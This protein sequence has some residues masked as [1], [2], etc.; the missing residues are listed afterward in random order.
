[1]H[2]TVDAGCDTNGTAMPIQSRYDPRVRKKNAQGRKDKYSAE[3]P[4]RKFA[5]LVQ[6]FL[7]RVR[8]ESAGKGGKH[9]KPNANANEQGQRE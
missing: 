4:D 1:M 3:Y 2:K 7:Q 9:E 5:A 8:T 6:Q